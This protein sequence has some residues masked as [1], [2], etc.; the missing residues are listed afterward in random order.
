MFA[1]FLHPKSLRGALRA[2]LHGK[3]QTMHGSIPVWVQGVM[4]ILLNQLNMIFLCKSL[5]T[6]PYFKL[7]I[8]YK[9]ISESTPQLHLQCE[10]HGVHCFFGNRCTRI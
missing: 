5:I 6:V 3:K 7:S 8:I 2:T 1:G 9:I 4:V 10:K